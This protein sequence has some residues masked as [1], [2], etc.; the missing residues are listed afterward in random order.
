MQI[1]K[2]YEINDP[3]W[4]HIS[5]GKLTKGKVVDYFDLEHAGYPKTTEFYTIEIVTHIDPI[6]EIRTWEQM[7]QDAKGPIGVY[8]LMKNSAETTKFLGKVGIE[9]PASVDEET[10]ALDPTP[11]QVN[12][13]IERAERASK[14][15]YNSPL[16]EKPKRFYKRKTTKKPS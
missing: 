8:R 12:A 6:L 2:R 5:S 3:V 11:E 4:I 16:T 13:A 10:D 15:M 7:S 9:L 14:E 1:K